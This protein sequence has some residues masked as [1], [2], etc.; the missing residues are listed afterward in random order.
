MTIDGILVVDAVSDFPLV[1]SDEDAKNG[2]P[3]DIER[4]PGALGCRRSP[5]VIRAQ[6]YKSRAFLL[7][8][9]WIEGAKEKQ[10]RWE[11]YIVPR[12]L[13]T[14]EAIVDNEGKFTPGTFILESPPKY[15]RVTGKQQGSD[16]RPLRED[17]KPRRAPYK[18]KMR[19]NAPTHG[20]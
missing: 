2:V 13:R 15:H 4:C 11:R 20:T 19:V 9:M 18:T 14:Q 3:M 17:G 10:L 6:V 1:V 5:A 16:K 7:K 8:E 12:S